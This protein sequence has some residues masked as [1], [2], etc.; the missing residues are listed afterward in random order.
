MSSSGTGL[1]ASRLFITN[2]VVA[3][4]RNPLSLLNSYRFYS[5]KNECVAL[6]VE[7]AFV[8]KHLYSKKQAWILKLMSLLS[9]S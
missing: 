2:L 1:Q 7:R 4:T 5:R 3:T 6:C 9:H 8:I